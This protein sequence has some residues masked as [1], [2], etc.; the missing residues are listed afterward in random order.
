MSAASGLWLERIRN[1]NQLPVGTCPNGTCPG[2]VNVFSGAVQGLQS[3]SDR[4]KRRA[5]EL[6]RLERVGWNRRFTKG[7]GFGVSY[8]YSKSYDN[9]SGRAG[10]SV[11]QL[12]RQ[13]FLGSVELSIR[14]TSSSSTGST[15]CR[16][17]N[18]TASA[19][20][21]SAAGRS[22]ESPSSRSG[23]P[24]TVGSNTDYAGIGTSSFQP[25]QVSGDPVLWTRR[26][27]LREQQR[28]SELLVPREEC[29]WIADFHG[30][31]DGDILQ[32]DA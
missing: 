9:A 30:A 3:D 6:Q 16:T 26:S 20:P 11:Q 7:F 19:A 25:W 21:S 12:R 5:L 17:R 22:P 29:R 14:A 15:S 4:R 32:P 28:R 8:T 1:L 27:R 13:E 18:R 31:H 23:V 2:G 10:H 24:F